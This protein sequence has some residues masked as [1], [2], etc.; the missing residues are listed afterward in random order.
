M[1]PTSLLGSFTLQA[2]L[3]CAVLPGWPLRG[4]Q[5]ILSFLTISLEIFENLLSSWPFL[6]LYKS[7]NSKI[8]SWDFIKQ[9][10]AFFELQSLGNPGPRT[11][12]NHFLLSARPH[13]GIIIY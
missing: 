7:L 9:S 13:L 1:I 5:K 4:P 8:Q 11:L 3:S 2:P 10:L 12:I 6:S